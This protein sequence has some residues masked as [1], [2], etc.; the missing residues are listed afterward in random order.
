[1]KL[2]PPLFIIALLISGISEATVRKSAIS[3]ELVNL[4]RFIQ[5]Y[6]EKEGKYPESWSEFERV[7]PN[8]DKTFSVLTPTRRMVLLSPPLELPQR[9]F[10]GGLAIAMTRDSYRP[11]TWKQWP[12][13]G[14]TYKTLKN[15]V[16]GVVVTTNG[17][18]SR[19]EIPPDAM[20]S[21]FVA[22]GLTLPTPSG[23]GAFKYE[24]EL[25]ARRSFN[26]VAVV[27]FSSWVIWMLIRRIK[28]QRSEQFVDDNPL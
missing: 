21:I 10:G 13:I 9:F 1:M 5:L 12:I 4:G 28:N 2:L 15:P 3:V 23:L 17:G 25:M 26:W 16:Y 27:A 18:V 19:R 7:T 14:T 6:H 11:V 8:L 20:S 22:E 24:K